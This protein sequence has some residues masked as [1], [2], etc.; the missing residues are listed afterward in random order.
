MGVAGLWNTLRPAAKTRSLTDLAVNDGFETNPQ[1]ARGYRIGIDASIWFFHM[2]YGREGEN[3]HLRT[4]FFRCAT[5]MRTPFLPL[6]VFDGPKRPDFKRG[7]RINTSQNVLIPS[8]K[9]IIEAFGFEHR[10]APGEAEAELAYLNSIGV[11]DGVLSDDVDNFLFGATTVIRNPSNSL[12]GNRSN[13]VLNSAGKDDKNHSWVYKMEDIESHPEIGLTRGGLILI[14]LLSG[15][16][17]EQGG[18]QGCGMQKA[19]ALAKCGF[20]DSLYKAA[21]TL[22]RERLPLFLDNWRHEMRHEISTNSQGHLGR[23]SPA[24]AKSLTSAFPDIDIL[25]SYVNPITSETMGKPYSPGDILWNKEP[26]ISKL[27]GICER[28]FEW[29]YKEAIIKRFRTVMW[30]SAVQRILRRAVLDLDQGKRSGGASSQRPPKTPS[31]SGRGSA[32]PCGTPSKMITQYFSNMSITSSRRSSDQDED[33]EERLIVKIHSTRT[34]VST[35]GLLEYRVEVAPAQLVRLAEHGIQGTRPK[36]TQEWESEE[37]GDGDKDQAS[38]NPQE[39]MR[40]WMPACMVQ[41]VEPGLVE[42]F[43][44]EVARK[45]AKKAGKGQGRG[46]KKKA[47]DDDDGDVPV[48]PP[49]AK[50]SRARAA[51]ARDPEDGDNTSAAPKGRSKKATTATSKSKGKSKALA[52]LSSDEESEG[53][54]PSPSRLFPSARQETRISSKT[55]VTE[56]QTTDVFSSAGGFDGLSPS[57]R[58]R[59]G[60]KDLTK[61]KTTTTSTSSTT[62]S[63]TGAGISS[64]S[65]PGVPVPKFNSSSTSTKSGTLSSLINPKRPNA[66]AP[67]TVATTSTTTTI[68]AAKSKSKPAPFPVLAF[69]DDKDD[70]DD[71]DGEMLD[72][73]ALFTSPSRGRKLTVNTTTS[74]SASTSNR[75][76]ASTSNSTSPSTSSK[77]GRARKTNKPLL[78]DSSDSVGSDS[79]LMRYRKSPRKSSSHS[80][81]TTPNSNSPRSGSPTPDSGSNSRSRGSNGVIGIGVPA[82]AKM[83]GRSVSGSSSAS[84]APKATSSSKPPPKSKSKST[85]ALPQAIKKS[86]DLKTLPIYEISS[87]SDED[88]DDDELPARVFSATTK[89]T[90]STTSATSTTKTRETA[91]T[92]RKVK[93]AN[94][95]STAR[96][97]N[98]QIDF[99]D[100]T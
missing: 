13:P 80:S 77:G 22:S 33:D 45:A 60:V 19:V 31:R 15:G 44:A 72:Y 8:M 96:K 27:A 20:G 47:A 23:K 48:S 74:N 87:D 61:K 89:K 100:L 73:N 69:L 24:L 1:G 32:E 93:T 52:N 30:H 49:K 84:G 14:G 5:L 39:H 71:D 65:Q 68:T 82:K 10:T 16:D 53:E 56:S 37:E 64:T 46:K 41:L 29:G 76:S 57:P 75:T 28:F 79:V 67:V 51:P 70:D 50:P 18:L 38:S 62:F 36:P 98:V 9:Q 78:S 35:D 21:T 42:V 11:I 81:P 6:F 7:K 12:S 91:T 3:P 4:L 25:L 83:I 88:D 58:L 59:V 92:T 2:E 34:H 63:T 54:L 66:S 99:I 90:L 95:T 86:V 85:T 55:I 43:D 94:S 17:Y 97:Q 26:D 40:L